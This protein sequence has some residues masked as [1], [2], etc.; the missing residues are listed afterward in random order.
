MFLFKAVSARFWLF[1][2]LSS[3]PYGQRLSFC[4]TVEIARNVS[5]DRNSESQVDDRIRSKQPIESINETYVYVNTNVL[6]R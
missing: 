4:E 1:D 2:Q 5:F 3:Q 6:D